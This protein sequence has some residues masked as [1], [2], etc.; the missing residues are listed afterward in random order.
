MPARERRMERSTSPCRCSCSSCSC[1]TSVS[2]GG[3]TVLFLVLTKDGAV[4]GAQVA[5]GR[6]LADA[7]RAVA[8]H[9]GG[10]QRGGGGC[11]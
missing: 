11:F 2:A 5:H 3:E 1:S 9:H 10:P 6:K 4:G 8:R 7:E